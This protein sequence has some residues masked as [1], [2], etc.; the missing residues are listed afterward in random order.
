MQIYQTSARDFK[1]GD[2]CVTK[3]GASVTVKCVTGGRY[4]EIVEDLDI[5]VYLPAHGDIGK[6]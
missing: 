4:V 5:K 1:P 2:K 6:A 3:Y